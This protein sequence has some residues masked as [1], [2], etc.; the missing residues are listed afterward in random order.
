M[1]KID[2]FH[3]VQIK[4]ENMFSTNEIEPRA[5]PQIG[6]DKEQTRRPSLD[7]SRRRAT[8]I[9]Q[10]TTKSDPIMKQKYFRFQ[11]SQTKYTREWKN[12]RKQTF[13]RRRNKIQ[14]RTAILA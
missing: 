10:D 2:K 4:F 7:D 8:K 11:P 1:I 12:K 13:R 9:A 5:R 6:Q 14:I 3:S